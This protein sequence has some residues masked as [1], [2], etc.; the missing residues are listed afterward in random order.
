M[1]DQPVPP[2]PSALAIERLRQ[3]LRQA[4]VAATP[5]RAWRRAAV[6]FLGAA[7]VGGVIAGSKA[8]FGRPDAP[9][10][11]H[12]GNAQQAHNP[13]PLVGRVVLEGPAPLPSMLPPAGG[14]DCAHRH[15]PPKDESILVGTGGGVAN[16]VVCISAGLPA[17]RTFAAPSEPAVLDQKDC[18]YLPR[19][20][21]MQVGQPLVA[22]NSDPF[23]HNV[24]TNPR[25]N[26]PVN[27]PQPQPDPVG[28]HLKRIETAET[29]KVTC[30]LHP[31]MVA[32]V[33]AFDHP[34]NAV[35]APD[36]SFKMPPLEPG[37]YTV[38][39]WHERLGAVEEQI[40]VG[41]DW[42]VPPIRLKFTQQHL[43]AALADRAPTASLSPQSGR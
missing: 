38:R 16:V 28:V 27:V 1:R 10:A 11:T 32:W 14:P 23:F 42:K 6:L 17:D 15:A 2:G 3:S 7:G 20:V 39:A 30:D 25:L 34:Y 36:G 13:P 26:R 43:A 40:V 12:D 41:D 19:V 8:F 37:Q 31:W 29:F 9:L 35:S 18:K 21:A 4:G 24:H 22:K 5:S 33:A